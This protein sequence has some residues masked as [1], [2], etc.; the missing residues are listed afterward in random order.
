MHA[1]RPHG[2]RVGIGVGLLFG[3]AALGCAAD[4]CGY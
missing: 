3:I 4:P 2:A 1:R